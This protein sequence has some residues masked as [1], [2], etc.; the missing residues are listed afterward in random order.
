MLPTVRFEPIDDDDDD[1]QIG[2]QDGEALG[3]DPRLRVAVIRRRTHDPK[4]PPPPITPTGRQEWSRPR[5]LEDTGSTWGP[6]S[7]RMSCHWAELASWSAETPTG[8]RNGR[9]RDPEDTGSHVGSEICPHVMP[10]G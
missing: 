1:Q 2:A 7:V 4:A 8:G 10:L 5:V 6:R 9:E 3:M